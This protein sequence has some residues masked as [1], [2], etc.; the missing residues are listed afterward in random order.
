MKKN[1]QSIDL[2]VR[3]TDLEEYW[4]GDF[5]KLPANSTYELVIDYPLSFPAHYKIN[6]GKNGMGLMA[7]LRKIGKLYQKTYDLDSKCSAYN[8]YGHDIGDLNLAGIRVNHK[9]KTIKLDVDS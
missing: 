6:T 8:I 7:L 5:Q 1:T 4:K 3:I 2:S 9:T